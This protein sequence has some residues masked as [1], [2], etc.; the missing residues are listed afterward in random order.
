MAM[1]RAVKDALDPMD[2]FNPGKAV[3]DR[4]PR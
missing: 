4:Q 3:G 2:L 1:Q